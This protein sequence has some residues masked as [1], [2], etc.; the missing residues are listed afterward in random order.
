MK[1]NKPRISIRSK[2]WL[3]IVGTVAAVIAVLWLLQVVYLEDYYLRSK[4]KEF[5]KIVSEVTAAVELDGLTESKD[6]LFELASQY[7][8][9][10]DVCDGYG[11][12]VVT[13]E[14]LNYNCY[15]HKNETRRLEFLNYGIA[16]NGEKNIVTIE[17]INKA[18][19]YFICATNG[20]SDDSS[21]YIL[22]ISVALAPV[23]EA[24]LAIRTQ[25][26]VIAALLFLV[27]MGIAFW[28]TRSLTKNIL[29]INNAAKQV[30]HGNMAVEVDVYS[31]DELGDLAVSFIEMTREISKV[32]VLQRELVANISHDIRTPLT[33][34][35]GYAET[36]KDITGDNK[37][38]REHQLDIII[39]ETN[40][41]GTLVS[42]VMD[43][44]LM[45]AGQAPLNLKVFDM[46]QKAKA[47][48]SRF[49]LLEQTRDFS[50]L[51]NGEDGQTVF[52]DEVRVEQ[53]LYN[54]INN[55]VNHI[56]EQKV[57]TVEVKTEQNEVMVSVTDTGV[58]IAKED[59]PLIWDRYYKPYKNTER[60]SV[61]TGLGLSIVKAILVNHGSR[62]GV[63]S[64]LGVGS[65]FWF[66]LASGANAPKEIGDGSQQK[67]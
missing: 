22:T 7:V 31:N 12:R 61:G 5:S 15:I 44:S 14:G 50:F 26:L 54:L 24:A 35:K 23:R 38:T 16:S 46:K 37:E 17:G 62:F 36:I 39:N 20:Q 57:I 42:N 55:A 2:V 65:C 41:L 58:G 10:I 13:Y 32:N 48:L 66:T 49:E 59:L 51:L 52:A 60:K 1:F 30:A 28:I 40:R 56:G 8:L 29:K 6:K 43:L 33:M 3:A 27:A 34:I 67:Q 4:K 18:D 25:F 63:S 53:V 11:N 19:E 45:Q 47:I 9:C 21:S 64:T